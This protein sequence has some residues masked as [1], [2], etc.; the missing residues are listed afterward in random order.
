[1]PN[2]FKHKVE[3]L[4]M[5]QPN[6]ATCWWASYRMIYKFRNRTLDEIDSKLKPIINLE[7]CKANGLPDTD[8]T[9]V[10]NAL[11][12]RG[13]RGTEFNKK[14]GFFDIGLSDGAEAFL[15]E[16]VVSPLWVSRLIWI[17]S[18]KS[19]HIVV[20]VGYDDDKETII[21][22]NPYPGPTDAKEQSMKANL[23]VKFITAANAS[24]QTL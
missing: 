17:G 18:E 13:W 14:Q 12:L 23:F 15:K 22:N 9:R 2:T 7:D 3:T 19:Y 24:V 4:G 1:M 20:A 11:G 8:Y 16:L 10:A 6:N 5:G 21:Y